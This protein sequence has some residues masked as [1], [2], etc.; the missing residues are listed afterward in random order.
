[1]IRAAGAR[2]VHLRISSPPTIGPCHYGIDTP[3]REE[4]IAHQHSVEEIRAIIGADS[5]GYLS[6]EGLRRCG[7]RLKHGFCDA[8][9][10]DE[11][12]VPSRP[13]RDRRRSSRCS[14]RWTPTMPEPGA[15]SP[16]PRRARARR[17]RRQHP[18]RGHRAARPVRAARRQADHTRASSS[19]R[20][21]TAACTCATTCSRATWRWTRR[22]AT[23]S[24]AGRPGY[25]DL[26]AVPDLAHAAA[27]GVARGHRD[28]ALRRVRART[29][30]RS[31][32]RRA[33]SCSASSSGS[34][35][36]ASPRRWAASSSSSCCATTTRP[37]TRRATATSSR[38]STTSRTITSS[39]ARASRT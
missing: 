11:Y 16:R 34:P 8:C 35:R 15:G 33:G 39:R 9:F 1:M 28:R 25:G 30:R 7:A 37:R 22:P 27:R 29:A 6:L 14:G 3:T 26:H 21:P 38:P 23:R 17:G 36:A 24:R 2:E 12:P 20:S 5:L 4:L 31:R 13:R 19:T 18:H 10:S 32:S